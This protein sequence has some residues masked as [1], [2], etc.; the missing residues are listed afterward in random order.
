MMESKI[1]RIGKRN[2]AYI[3]IAVLKTV[4]AV[5]H[6]RSWKASVGTIRARIE[7]PSDLAGPSSRFLSSTRLV[8]GQN[9]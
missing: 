2:R 3:S 8:T 4:R 9:S 1:E 6:G 7:I 5:V